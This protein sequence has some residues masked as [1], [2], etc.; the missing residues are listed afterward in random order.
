MLAEGGGNGGH[1]G[2]FYFN[3]DSS[4]GTAFLFLLGDS[5]LD[6]S[7]HNSPGVS[8]GDLSGEGRIYL[9]A[10]NLTVG[11]SGFPDT[12]TGPIRDGGGASGGG[13]L[14]KVGNSQGP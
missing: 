1:A 12:L 13:S 4:G 3:G 9:G 11:E 5:V 6:I 2:S 7:G 8:L 14:T 10:N